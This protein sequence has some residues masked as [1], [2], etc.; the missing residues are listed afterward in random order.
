MNS[1]NFNLEEKLKHSLQDNNAFLKRNGI[2][3]DEEKYI[4]HKEEE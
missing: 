1:N 4:W 2:I 3:I